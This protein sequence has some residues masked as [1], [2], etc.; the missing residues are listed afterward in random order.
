MTN[1]A[2]AVTHGLPLLA[3]I[4]DGARTSRTSGG[5][6]GGAR[7]W[8]AAVPPRQDHVLVLAGDLGQD[9]VAQGQ[10]PRLAARVM[11][12][13]LDQGQPVAAPLIDQAQQLHG[14]DGHEHIIA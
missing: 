6:P 7:P 3:L 2:T 4:A 5:L 10:L 8:L 9:P 14:G 11:P 1:T 12:A 13:V